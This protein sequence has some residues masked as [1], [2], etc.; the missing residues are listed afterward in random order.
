MS[1]TYIVGIAETKRLFCW[2]LIDELMS[3][4]WDSASLLPGLGHFDTLFLFIFIFWARLRQLEMG[5]WPLHDATFGS[6][7]C[8]PEPKWV[9]PCEP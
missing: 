8:R 9:E 6:I 2:P 5:K 1:G 7:S 4:L 3:R